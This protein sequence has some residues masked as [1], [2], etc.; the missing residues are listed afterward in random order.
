[1]ILSTSP[2]RAFLRTLALILSG[3]AIASG[4]ASGQFPEPGLDPEAANRRNGLKNM[5]RRMEDVGGTF[6]IRP[7]SEGGALVRLTVPLAASRP[8]MPATERNVTG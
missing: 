4:V 6:E 1:M 8:A 5:R 7:G 3:V 2:A